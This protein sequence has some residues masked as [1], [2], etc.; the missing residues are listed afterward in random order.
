M[1]QATLAAYFAD[2]PDPRISAK[3]DHRLLDIILLAICAVVCRAETWEEIE[4]FGDSKL[5]WL[6]Q[7]LELPNG[8]PSHDTIERVF[9]KLDPQAFQARFQGWVQA[10]FAVTEGQVVAIDGKTVRGADGSQGKSNLHLVS[11]WASANGITLGQMKVNAKSNEITAIPELLKLLV[12]K[13]C[14]VTLDALGCQTAIAEQIVTQDADYVLAV[15]QNQGTLYQHVE[16][17]FTL[18]DDERF[19]HIQAQVAETVERGHG[20]H[21]TRRCWVLADTTPQQSGW[22]GCQT[23]V[24]IRRQRQLPDKQEE[25]TVY[26]ISTLPPQPALLLACVRAHWAIENSFHWVLDVVFGEDAHRTRTLKAAENLAL[27]RRIALNLL[28]QH[29]AKTGLKGTLKGK[30]FRAGLNEDFLLEVL[31]A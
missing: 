10:V 12:L 16:S 20:R 3:C 27:L 28:K 11:A 18:A 4:W 5:E 24:R 30:R 21:E 7:W 14:I 17:M 22:V 1:S 8:I 19:A 31:R 2:L 25:E 13:G 23:L 15:K 9:N 29:T 6:Q 26:F